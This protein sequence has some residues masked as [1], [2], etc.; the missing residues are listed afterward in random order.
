MA[1]EARAGAVAGCARPARAPSVPRAHGVRTCTT[2]QCARSTAR[3]SAVSTMPPPQAMTVRAD[4]VLSVSCE[5]TRVVDA[6]SHTKL[7]AQRSY[8]SP[9]ASVRIELGER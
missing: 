3:A 1:A 4:L 6:V 2:G 7:G 9:V 8:I 5:S